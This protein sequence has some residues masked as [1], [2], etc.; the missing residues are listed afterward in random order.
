M[1]RVEALG[2]IA[3]NAEDRLIVCNLGDPARELYAVADREENFYMLGSMGLA[4]SI[5]LGLAIARRERGVIAIDGDGSVMMNLG[6]LATIAAQAPDDFLLVIVDNGVYGSTGGQPSP[7]SGKADL[8]GMAK[9]AGVGRVDV[10]ST[11][12]ELMRTIR[13]MRSGVL[14]VRVDP[15][16]AA[17][18]LIDIQPRDILR[19][20]MSA[21]RPSP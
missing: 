2:V 13:P 5:G 7:T 21:A 19:R 8:A 16:S 12:E 17:A 1:R 10:V 4:S 14:I 15:S 18:P 20:F 3:E 11:M 6:S 9:A